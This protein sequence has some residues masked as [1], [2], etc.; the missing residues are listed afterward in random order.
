MGRKRIAET[1]FVFGA[2]LVIVCALMTVAM[3]KPAY[4]EPVSSRNYPLEIDVEAAKEG[5][6]VVSVIVPSSVSIVVKTSMVD[7]RV[8]G[9][10]GGTAQVSNSNRSFAP[11][12]LSVT[13]AEDE[14]VTNR[15]F[16]SY[17]DMMLHGDHDYAVRSGENQN[18]PLFDAI[19]PGSQADLEASIAQK[20]PDV[21]IPAGSYLVRTTLLVEPVES[22]GAEGQE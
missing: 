11:I 21:L 3:P 19:A 15:G 1:A 22:A 8:M 13:S 5:E 6:N 17:V 2:A 9:F 18:A 16:L 10:V 4:A 20:Y 12:A 14:P 7:G